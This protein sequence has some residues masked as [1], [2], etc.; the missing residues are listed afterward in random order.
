M[1]QILPLC[2][3]DVSEGAMLS[4]KGE[5]NVEI[6]HVESFLNRKFDK[7]ISYLRGGIVEPTHS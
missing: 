1:F 3:I 2:G 7:S 4:R 5:N 6:W